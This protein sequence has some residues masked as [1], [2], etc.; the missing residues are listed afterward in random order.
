[1]QCS[2]I[3][4]PKRHW[5]PINCVLFYLC[6][7]RRQTNIINNWFL[8][9]IDWSNKNKWCLTVNRRRTLLPL[10]GLC[11]LW[12]Q[13]YFSSFH[14]Q[15]TCWA[16]FSRWPN[17]LRIE[18]LMLKM[19]SNCQSTFRFPDFRYSLFAIK[20]VGLAELYST[21]QKTMETPKLNRFLFIRQTK[22]R[23]KV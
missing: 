3:G 20:S 9:L 17:V 18:P 11:E 23:Y 4:Q 12:W 21:P 16:Q 14:L 7:L 13:S 22:S 10:V 15:R 6:V 8:L 1:M 19:L 5:S 2:R